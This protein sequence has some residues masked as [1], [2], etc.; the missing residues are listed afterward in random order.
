MKQIWKNLFCALLACLLA[1]SA[2]VTFPAAG[3]GGSSLLLTRLNEDRITY[4]ADIF[5]EKDQTIRKNSNGFG[6]AL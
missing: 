6:G 5:P 4:S 3:E 2:A 1:A